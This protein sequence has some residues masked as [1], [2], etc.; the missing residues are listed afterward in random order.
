[1]KAYRESIAVTLIH[2]LFQ[3][4]SFSF[5]DCFVLHYSTLMSLRKIR[6]VSHSSFENQ[7]ERENI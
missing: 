6:E 1:M 4:A 7:T 5:N 3:E 2:T